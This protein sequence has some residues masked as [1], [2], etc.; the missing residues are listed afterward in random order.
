[1]RGEGEEGVRRSAKGSG[2]E[3]AINLSSSLKLAKYRTKLRWWKR[4]VPEGTE[5]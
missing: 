2:R 3:D 1:M 5:H 4:G